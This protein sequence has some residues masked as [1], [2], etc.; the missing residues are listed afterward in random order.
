MNQVMAQILDSCLDRVIHGTG[1]AEGLPT[2]ESA[3]NECLSEY[4]TVKAELEPLLRVAQH[5]MESFSAITPAADFND[6]ALSS[7]LNRAAKLRASH[8]TSS[9]GFF[10]RIKG[11]GDRILRAERLIFRRKAWATVLSI[12]LAVVLAG[13]TVKASL[14]AAPE[15]VLYPVKLGTEQVQLKLAP[16]PE[17]KARLHMK[18]A[19]RRVTE[20]VLVAEKEMPVDI[21]KLEIKLAANLES[22]RIITEE[23]KAQPLKTENAQKIQ[24]ELIEN[25]SSHITTLR[26]S[27][28][29][30]PPGSRR[31]LELVIDRTLMGYTGPPK[32]EV[33]FRMEGRPEQKAQDMPEQKPAA[34]EKTP[35][36]SAV[37]GGTGSG[38]RIW[39]IRPK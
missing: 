14:N 12:F 10:W 30:A 16:S 6:R 27:I 18:F 32:I 34:P 7:L 20:M 26:R 5:T 38:G 2:R 13:G 3:L 8:P 19:A 31:P 36:G 15:E 23:L 4:R 9:H 25:A 37:P 11:M 21:D 33:P 22:A 24:D 17:Q 28:S 29:T 1:A 39:N 35:E